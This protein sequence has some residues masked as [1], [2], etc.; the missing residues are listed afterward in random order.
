M[1]NAMRA[2]RKSLWRGPLNQRLIL[3]VGLPGLVFMLAIIAYVAWTGREQALA[4]GRHRT[5]ELSRLLSEEVAHALQSAD[6]GLQ[7]VRAILRQS[8][9]A[10][11]ADTSQLRAEMV[12]TRAQLSYVQHISIFDERGDLTLSTQDDHLP[13]NIADRTHFSVH[14]SADVGLY[15]SPLQRSRLTHQVVFFLSRRLADE[16]GKFRGVVIASIDP[17]YFN[18]LYRDLHLD[19]S[20]LFELTRQDMALLARE[21]ALPEADSLVAFEQPALRALIDANPAGSW[22]GTGPYDDQIRLQSYRQ[23][24]PFPLYVNV[25]VTQPA[26][27]AAWRA[28]VLPQLAVA[29]AAWLGL[30]SLTTI[31]YRAA[32][33]RAL[34]E[35]PDDVAQ[36]ESGG[37]PN[38]QSMETTIAE[39]QDAIREK[40]MLFRELNHRVKNNLQLISSLLS[41]QANRTEDPEARHS[42]EVSLDRVHSI[43]LVHELLYQRERTTYVDLPAYLKALCNRITKAYVPVDR[44]T[45]EIDADAIEMPLDLII[46]LALIVN[47][48]VTNAVKHA[49]PGDRRGHITVLFRRSEGQC[50]LMIAD[51]GVGITKSS[52]KTDGRLGLELV[53]LLSRY[54]EGSFNTE[55]GHF[56][57]VFTLSFRPPSSP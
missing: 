30:A 37:A 13:V 19:P 14:V 7:Q 41:L 21:P 56:G 20:S 52:N 12:A 22:A 29:L 57:T 17:T 11:P 32:G 46:R 51:D 42:L 27:L 8:H 2:T 15:V 5:A 35:E 18:S 25:G 3:W 10:L 1:T 55:T 33:R 47:E 54:F 4:A 31:A 24:L 49:F 45:C 26:V 40:E 44:I 6:M 9:G 34:G 38:A 16:H 53:E 39:L 23:A 43:G 50:R 48:I 28:Q 36:V